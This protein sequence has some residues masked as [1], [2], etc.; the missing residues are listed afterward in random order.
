MNSF[1]A[2][3]LT[4][5]TLVMLVLAWRNAS[6]TLI[7]FAYHN[8]QIYFASDSLYSGSHGSSNRLVQKIFP[9]SRTAC[10]ALC[11]DYGANVVSNGVTLVNVD[12]LSRL[13]ELAT[14][15]YLT[16]EGAEVS[17]N[18]LVEAFRKNHDAYSTWA[19][20]VNWPITNTGIMFCGYDQESGRFFSAYASSETRFSPLTNYFQSDAMHETGRPP[21]FLGESKFAGDL[22]FPTV[23]GSDAPNDSYKQFRTDAFI[24]F[25]RALCSANQPVSDED[26]VK[27]FLLIFQLHH[28]H[29][30]EL[31][32]APEGGGISEPYVIY[33][34][35]ETETIKLH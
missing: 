17:V 34:I 23:L 8:H 24:R 21:T 9:I 6:A 20:R 1:K 26:V 29:A 28:Q 18:H 16:G 22:V 15:S 2:R 33:K 31:T 27:Y 10:V 25:I 11:N 5:C 14:N 7:I 19:H 32:H 30:T 13:G 4:W 12:L 35:T 3:G